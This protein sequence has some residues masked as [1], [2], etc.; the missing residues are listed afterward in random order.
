MISEVFNLVKDFPHI[1]NHILPI[2]INLVVPWSSQSHMQDS[3]IF[4]HIDL[5][6]QGQEQGHSP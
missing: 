1:W 3:T 2:T 6:G 4:S 5:Q